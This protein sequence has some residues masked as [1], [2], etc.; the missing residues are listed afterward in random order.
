MLIDYENKKIIL[1]TSHDIDHSLQFIKEIHN[2]MDNID[3][4]KEYV[5]ANISFEC[6]ISKSIG[7]S[8]YIESEKVLNKFQFELIENKKIK[9][10]KIK[11]NSFDEMFHYLKKYRN[12]K[13]V[14]PYYGIDI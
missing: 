10:F 6:S 1:E 3:K 14:F 7:E 4:I 2:N 12:D 9:K 8:Y 13:N 11:F 5:I